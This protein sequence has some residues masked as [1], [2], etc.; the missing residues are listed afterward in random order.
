MNTPA[1]PDRTL[2]SPCGV[3][4]SDCAAHRAKDDP[5]VMA[6]MIELG[7]KKETL[8]CPGCRPLK[9]KCPVIGGDCETYKCFA[10]RNISFCYECADF[11][12]DKLLPAADKAAFAIHNLKIY[13]LCF[14]KR[15][16][17]KAWQEASVAIKQKYFQGKLVYGKGPQ[18]G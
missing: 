3:D 13:N 16:G 6:K 11:P 4:C 7:F 1:S 8:P 10:A 12:C 17:L 9:G 14:I 2:A 5:A 18:I 15:S